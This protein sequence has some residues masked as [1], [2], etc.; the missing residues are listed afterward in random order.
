[1][2]RFKQISPSHDS[3]SACAARGP[4][5]KEEGRSDSCHPSLP[6]SLVT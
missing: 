2:V 6:T 4:A 1:V 3:P 5:L